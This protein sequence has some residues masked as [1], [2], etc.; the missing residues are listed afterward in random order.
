MNK[1]KIIRGF[2]KGL[3]GVIL[4]GS[5]GLATLTKRDNI[6]ILAGNGKNAFG[7]Q[8]IS[9]LYN[10]IKDSIS[11]KDNINVELV[12]NGVDEINLNEMKK[13]L[14]SM[15]KS[16]KTILIQM[17]GTIECGQF[18]FINGDVKISSQ[19]LFSDIAQV[20]GNK[21]VDIIVSSC[22]AGGCLKD[23]D[24]LPKGSFVRSIFTK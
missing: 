15:K 23:K 9:E 11:N 16:K 13:K 10:N 1:E 17:H 12:G 14:G 20:V 3:A 19:V 7:K 4:T 6:L 22:H 5:L 2:V 21:P 18:Y 24:I 8:E